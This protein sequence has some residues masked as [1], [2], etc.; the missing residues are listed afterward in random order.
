MEA[1]TTFV[2]LEET[3][4]LSMALTGFV[5]ILRLAFS[6]TPMVTAD[7]FTLILGTGGVGSTQ[8]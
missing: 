1:V 7:S 6:V 3:K 2:F 4:M 8:T 5:F